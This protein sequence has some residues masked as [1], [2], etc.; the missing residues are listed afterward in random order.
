MFL[1][2]LIDGRVAL[3][4]EVRFSRPDATTQMDSTEARRKLDLTAL[5]WG[6]LYKA[7]K[8]QQVVLFIVAMR[9]LS[10]VKSLAVIREDSIGAVACVLG[11]D[12]LNSLFSETLNS[13]P[14]F[15]LD[16]ASEPQIS[17]DQT[18]STST[19]SDKE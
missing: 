17:A 7:G 3:S 13:R 10:G 12:V 4:F 2:T 18:S 11:R 14:Q 15:L 8:I 16:L 5:E 1:C 6:P 19:F 9:N